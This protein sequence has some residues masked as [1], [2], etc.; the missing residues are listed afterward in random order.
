MK[1]KFDFSDADKA[2]LP[3]AKQRLF[4]E[5][6]DRDLHLHIGYSSSWYAGC[7]IWITL[8]LA[9]LRNQPIFMPSICSREAW[10]P[11]QKLRDLDEYVLTEIGRSVPIFVCGSMC[12]RAKCPT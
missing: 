5:G 1:F 7:E 6:V 11:K 10:M 2:S 12:T 3:E 9:N 8:L 4:T